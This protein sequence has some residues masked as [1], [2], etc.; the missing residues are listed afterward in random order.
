MATDN[1]GNRETLRANADIKVA[2]TPDTGAA[3]I[4]GNN[5]AGTVENTPVSLP[6]A[7][8]LATA[9]RPSGLS[10]KIAS[11]TPTSTNGGT[12]VLSDKVII[13]TPVLG[14]VGQDLFAYILDDG[15]DTAQGTVA[16]TVASGNGPS[17]NKISITPQSDGNLVMQFAGIPGR[18]YRV[19]SAPTIT[20]PW[21]D[22]SDVIIADPTGLIQFRTPAA[23]SAQFY[24]IRSVVQ[25]P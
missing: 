23:G 9:K 24:R 3:L 10:L 4:A 5:R 22:L 7:K 2:I 6:V 14:F 17:L 11:V 18:S 12:V 21:A 16:I 13:Y 25:N 19:Q 20:G 1:V 15:V 8:L